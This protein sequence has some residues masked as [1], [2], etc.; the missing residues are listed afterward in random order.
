VPVR[1]ADDARRKVDA[2]Y[3]DGMLTI[4]VPKA[5]TAVAKKILIK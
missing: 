5:A 2:A 3:Q 4:H 1:A